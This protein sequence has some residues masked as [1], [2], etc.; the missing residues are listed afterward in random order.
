VCERISFPRTPALPNSAQCCCMRC[1]LHQCLRLLIEG[2][3]KDG[4]AEG[5][6]DEESDSGMEG[7]KVKRGR[8]EGTEGGKGGRDGKNLICSTQRGLL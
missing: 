6:G 2:T 1:H 8:D 7:R 3:I 4:A 5:Y